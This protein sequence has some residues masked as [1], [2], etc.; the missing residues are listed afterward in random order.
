MNQMHPKERC[1]A[2]QADYSCYF[3]LGLLILD[4]SERACL[5]RAVSAAKETPVHFL[6]LKQ[7]KYMCV[8][9][10]IS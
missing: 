5:P 9:V 1:E 3:I 4:N 7:A 2:N 8:T 6:S 10:T